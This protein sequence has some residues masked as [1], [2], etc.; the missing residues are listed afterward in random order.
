[1][2]MCNIPSDPDSMFRLASD[3]DQFFAFAT[4]MIIFVVFYAI[5]SAFISLRRKLYSDEKKRQEHYVKQNRIRIRKPDND[6][7][8]VDYES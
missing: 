1:M 8:K 3:L 2:T 4:L 5:Y 6:T 7:S